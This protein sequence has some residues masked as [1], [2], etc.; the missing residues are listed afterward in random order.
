MAYKAV[1][2]LDDDAGQTIAIGDV[3]GNEVS[4]GVQSA[5]MLRVDITSTVLS[6]L[7]S[8]CSLRHVVRGVG[9]NVVVS[10]QN[11]SVNINRKS[12]QIQQPAEPHVVAPHD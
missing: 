10:A 6:F 12:V 2:F 1:A 9:F 8:W 11:F 7:E 4:V 5:S 3:V